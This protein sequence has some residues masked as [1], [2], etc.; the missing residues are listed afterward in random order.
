MKGTKLYRNRYILDEEIGSGGFATIYRAKEQDRSEMVAIKVANSSEDP[1]FAKSLREEAKIIQRFNHQNIVQLQAIPRLDK[2]GEV[3][4]A[5]AL[6]LPGNPVFFVMEYLEGGTLN[7][8]LNQVE[9]LSVP[10]A[11]AIGV[12]VARGLDHMHQRGYAHN[13]LKLENVVFRQTVMAGEPFMAVLI[14]F[15]IATRVHQP[16]AGSLYIMPPEQ[17]ANVK[18]MAPPEMTGA[19][20]PTKIDVWGLGVVLYR[21]LGGQLPFSG[22]SERSLTQRIYNS[23][24]T[25]LSRLVR[26]I[27]PEMD[28]L[29][30]D[31]C[32]AKKPE[33]RLDLLE[34]GSRLSSIVGSNG[35]ALRSADAAKSSG[36]LG[37]IFGR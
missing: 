16:N 28:E 31:G 11:A 37:R 29:V 6:D 15:G 4:Y 19:I 27:T 12:Q 14:D 35:V 13:D 8:Y 10:E 3:F 33:N 2:E 17:L 7:A 34:L 23:R 25:S 32:L 20:D 26:D 30:I 9:K 24:P 1:S 18:M 36:I 5:N 21:M 22:R